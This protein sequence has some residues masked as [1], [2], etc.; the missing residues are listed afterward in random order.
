VTGSACAAEPER[1]NQRSGSGSGSTTTHGC[2][3]AGAASKR[4]TTEMWARPNF[5]HI[6]YLGNRGRARQEIPQDDRYTNTVLG[7]SVGGL[8]F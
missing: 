7:G 3:S 1:A 4:L 2:G 8:R 5:D 6:H